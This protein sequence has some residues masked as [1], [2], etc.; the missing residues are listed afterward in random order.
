MTDD[1]SRLASRLANLERRVTRLGRRIVRRDRDA[2]SRPRW[3]EATESPPELEE[4]LDRQVGEAIDEYVTDGTISLF[5][6]HGK[7]DGKV[8]FSVAEAAV[9][10][11]ECSADLAEVIGTWIDDCLIA[12]TG[13]IDKPDEARQLRAILSAAIARLDEVI[14][15]E[16]Q[17]DGHA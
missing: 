14:P 1:E 2:S 6:D 7:F 10:D 8:R 9:G 3:W 4:W 15:D 16:A 13:K 11:A 12:K 5:D 17:V